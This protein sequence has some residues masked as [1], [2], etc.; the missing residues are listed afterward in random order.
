MIAEY[1]KRLII[2]GGIVVIIAVLVAV[3]L[4][5]RGHS[6]AAAAAEQEAAALPDAGTADPSVEGADAGSGGPVQV[7]KAGQEKVDAAKADQSAKTLEMEKL[8]ED[9]VWADADGQSFVTFSQGKISERKGTRQV[10]A[11]Y[12]ITAPTEYREFQEAD[13]KM[14]VYTAAIRTDHGDFVMTLTKAVSVSDS[15]TVWHVDSSGFVLAKSYIKKAVPKKVVIEGIPDDIG[16]ALAIPQAEMQKALKAFMKVT[17][18]DAGKA[19]MS[20]RIVYDTKAN[21]V[22]MSFVVDNAAA[23]PITVTYDIASGKFNCTA[24]VD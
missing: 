2:L 3:P 10:D 24:K 18:P 23:T 11:D 20:S 9:G 5:V 21:T 8:L 17:F 6:G 15:T 14:S 4:V 19:T 1:K 22:E 16:K 13:S 12:E 7:E